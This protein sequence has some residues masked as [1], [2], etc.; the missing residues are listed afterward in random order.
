MKIPAPSIN[1][2]IIIFFK[3]FLFTHSTGICHFL[4]G[5]NNLIRWS[6]L[7]K[8]KTNNTIKIINLI[9]LGIQNVIEN[10]K[11]VYKNP[12]NAPVNVRD[13]NHT[14]EFLINFFELVLSPR[15]DNAN[16]ELTPQAVPIF[17]KPA[18]KA[19]TIGTKNEKTS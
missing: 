4:W 19:N 16:V 11:A 2:Q 15:G 6:S 1:P 12:V 7:H 10:I 17:V 14:K 5:I 13:N 3:S 9:L 18:V 8:Y